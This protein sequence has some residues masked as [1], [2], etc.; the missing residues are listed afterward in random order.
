MSL[1]FY[2]HPFSTAALT[3][4]ELI[5][6]G[7]PHEKVK[8]DLS[9]EKR[10]QRKPEFLAINPNGKV[11][12]IVDNGTVIF[13]SAAITLYLGEQYGVAKGLFPEAGAK[14]GEAMKWTVWTNV[15]LGEAFGRWWRNTSDRMP[16]EQR[17][18]ATAAEAKK[19]TEGYLRILDDALAGK[20]YL[21]GTFT[22]VDIHVASFID[23]FGMCGQ[24]LAPY[25]NITA[26][27]ARTE[28]RPSHKAF[29]DAAKS[30]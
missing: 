29:M 12:V 28:S 10:E 14:R 1:T 26:W 25:K 4:W 18:A 24:D 17:N 9:P 3:M 6:L 7:I 8:L 11:P 19:E 27:R 20:D 13:E 23:Y 22:L 30:A 15:T 21:L 16:A 2:Y 5:E